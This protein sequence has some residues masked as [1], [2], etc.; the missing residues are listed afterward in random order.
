MIFNFFYKNCEIFRK[1]NRQKLWKT[2]SR[3]PNRVFPSNSGI[4]PDKNQINH[5]KSTS[6][7]G[8]IVE[9]SKTH[10]SLGCGKFLDA[11]L[12][13]FAE[14]LWTTFCLILM[15]LDASERCKF[16]SFTV[17]LQIRPAL[18]GRLSLNSIFFCC[19]FSPKNQVVIRRREKCN[20]SVCS[21][22]ALL[23]EHNFIFQKVLASEFAWGIVFEK[24]W[25][26]SF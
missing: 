26:R 13:P 8:F 24:T 2:C 15:I 18:L 19:F 10:T 9:I 14:P 16:R 23:K 6:W 7:T 20:F 25:K 21:V 17:L 1:A 22:Q 3:H 11:F 4:K 12:D 5:Q